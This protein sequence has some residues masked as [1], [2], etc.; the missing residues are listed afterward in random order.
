[1]SESRG[2]AR[3]SEG[4]IIKRKGKKERGGHMW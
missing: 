4:K 1:V 2:K 3:G